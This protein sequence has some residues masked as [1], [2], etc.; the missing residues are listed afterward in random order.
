LSRAA[1]AAGRVKAGLLGAITPPPSRLVRQQSPQ[2]LRRRTTD[3]L[4]VRS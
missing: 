3:D 1:S 4:R 2:G